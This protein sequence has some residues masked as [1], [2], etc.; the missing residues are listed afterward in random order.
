MEFQPPLADSSSF[1]TA[2]IKVTAN[3][4]LPSSTASEW[5][6][7]NNIDVVG[8][9]E[10]GRTGFY[11]VANLPIISTVWLP[12]YH[13]PALVEP[14]IA[15]GK[16]VRLYPVLSDLSPD[17]SFLEARLKSRDAIVG[18]RY[19][20]F[21]C[22]IKKL[23]KMARE[24]HAL[25]I[26][27]LAHASFAEH[28]TGDIG[29]TSLGKF[30]PSQFG[31]EIWVKKS[32]NQFASLQK[33]H[34]KLPSYLVATIKRKIQTLKEK[35][36]G[37]KTKEYR[38]FTLSLSSKSIPR[39]LH[40]NIGHENHLLIANKR[41]NNYCFLAEC[42]EN[43]TI[44]RV[45]YDKLEETT[46]PYVLPFLLNSPDT[47][48]MIRNSGLQVYRWEEMADFDCSITKSYRSNLIHVPC[49]QNLSREQ[50]NSIC[51]IL[52]GECSFE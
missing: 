27:D 11:C 26:E 4:W 34:D 42:L 7:P 18:I 52:N 46:V 10:R 30:Y 40:S 8:M 14:F 28:L 12:S 19:F 20:G 37:G 3:E 1:P 35:I 32:S 24:K 49:H 39:Y 6:R 21:S 47:F 33:L 17:F 5:P 43:S 38:Y 29:V 51:K 50:L 44:G 22:A 15:A 9:V 41:K 48:N 31:A 13:C 2:T 25:L 36:F 45:L 16:K 23:A